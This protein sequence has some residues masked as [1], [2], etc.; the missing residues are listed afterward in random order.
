[1]EKTT[2]IDLTVFD[3]AFKQEEWD[4]ILE[5]CEG[6]GYT[7][8][9][10]DNSGT[11]PSGMV[12]N[13]SSFDEIH[14]NEDEDLDAQKLYDMLIAKVDQAVGEELSS[15]LSV[16]RVYINCFA[17]GEMPC[18]HQDSEEDPGITFLYYPQKEEWKLDDCG[19]TQFYIDGNISA[20]IP[21]PN[22]LVGFDPRLWHCAKSFRNRHRF[23]VAVKCELD[24]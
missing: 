8:G 15:K 22:R 20:I 4:Y 18:F 9:E 14:E 2:M 6:C 5:Y 1:M 21:K 19:E 3:D 12:H 16:Y 7:W 11:I 13:V 24:D 10:R 17:P 23:T